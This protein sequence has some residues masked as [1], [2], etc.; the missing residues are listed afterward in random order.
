MLLANRK[1][2]EYRGSKNN[3]KGQLMTL[4]PG[5]IPEVP[6]ETAKVA[7]A[8]FPKGNVYITMREKLGSIFENEDFADLYPRV[9]QYGQAPWQLALVTV[10]QFAEDLTDREAA[11]AVRGRIDWKYA[12]GLELTDAGFDFSVLSEFRSRLLSSKAETRLLEKILA[13]C[14]AHD[15][16]KA[17]GKQRTD[18][19]HV[20]GA[21]RLLNQLELVHETLR[22]CL[23]VL[24]E[25]I[26]DW[27]KKQVNDD[28]YT[29]YAK[30]LTEYHLPED[31][32]ARLDIAL[33]IGQ[34]GWSLL[35]Q[36]YTS[37]DADWLRRVP[38]VETLR[39]VWVQNYYHDRGNLQWRNTKNRPLPAQSIAS[40]HDTQARYSTK[41]NLTWV[42]Y[43]VHLTE[44][45]NP[46]N[47]N[48]IIQVETTP[49]TQHD[50]PAFEQVRQ[51]LRAAG[52]LPGEHLVD[53]SYMSVDALVE[54]ADEGIDLV[55]P[56][57]LDASWQARE[58]DGLDHT[59]FVINWE[60]EQ[61]I[62]PQGK[63]NSSWV[64]YADERGYDLV[65][66]K[67][68]K[69]DCAACPVRIRCTR[70]KTNPRMLTVHTQA[71]YE[72]LE[73]ARQHQQTQA[74]KDRYAVRAGVEG[75]VSQLAVALGLRQARYCG[76]AKIH[77]QSLATAAAANLLRVVAWLD[78]VP[79]SLTRKSA[80]AKL[81]A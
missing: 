59:C 41:R 14:K 63:Q 66:I 32:A 74:F 20:L 56:V 69:S 40:P 9:G 34:D 38:A 49:G 80:F 15:L 62:C 35:T 54:M 45:C 39:Q 44:T 75:T 8:A 43:K 77:L 3:A 61:A 6:T 27:L 53:A 64:S 79:R 72:A 65:K 16:L 52:R 25:I 2:V 22:H 24:A 33:R 28:W 50:S 12:L 73:T 58:P 29:Y 7:K 18:A 21:V 51:D 37:L 70:S 10:M 31:E 81:A 68:R 76:L 13:V 1:T 46:D 5:D 23:N 42:G 78:D 71:H 57:K 26:P 36:I 19:S 48:L 4:A 30:R 60:Q 17:N 67:F 47:P 11:D 55:G